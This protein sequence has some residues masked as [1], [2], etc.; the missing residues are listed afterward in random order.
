M[1]MTDVIAKKRDGHELSRE[2]IYELVKGYTDGS[3]PDYQMAAWAMAVY[4]QG[5]TPRETADLT[6]AMVES[7]DQLDLSAIPGIKVDKHSTGG[8]GDKITLVVAPLVASAG[9][10]V[11]KMSGRGLGF[12]G[13]TIDKLESFAGFQVELSQ[14]DFFRQVRDIGVAVIGQTGNLAPADKKLYALRDVTAT[15][16]AV[17]L[18]ASSIMSKK[19]AAGADAI[20]LDVKVGK[21][22]FMKTLEEAETLARAMV[23]IGEQV[24]RKT[25]A[26]ISDMNQPLG[27]A[28]GNALEVREA[29]DT[30][31][32]KGPDDLSELALTIGAHMLVLGQAEADFTAAY[33]LLRQQLAN[34]KALAKLAE[35]VSAQGGRAEAV[36]NPSLL[37][38][39]SHQI[40]VK[41]SQAGCISGIDAERIGHASVV[42]GAG[43]L[44]KGAPIDYAVGIVLSKKVGAEVAPGDTLAV[45]HANDLQLAETA[46]QEVEAAFSIAAESVQTQPLIRKII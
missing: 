46:R 29:I 21:G 17:P 33:E 7:G 12:S 8:V 35:L 11:A 1:R 9:I 38:R 14:A 15:V 18:I 24:G 36:E 10:P 6:M 3:I 42:L 27:Y 28:V 31:A 25:V 13:G 16:E 20:L 5:M 30:L 4:F 32:G 43:R 19:I 37:P 39:S 41:C 40:E 22:A 26:V 44:T 23:A 34:G 45:I 2:E